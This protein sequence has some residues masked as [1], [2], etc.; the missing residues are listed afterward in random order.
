M[1]GEGKASPG[2]PE[3]EAALRARYAAYSIK[4][5]RTPNK[6]KA[7]P[8]PRDLRVVDVKEERPPKGKEGMEW[9]LAAGE[10]AASPEEAYG[11]AGCY[12]RRWKAGRFHCALKGGR[13]VEKFQKRAID[14][15]TTLI[16]T[17]SI[18]GVM[19]LNMTYAARLAPESPC[20]LLLGE[21]EWKSLY[22]AANKSEQEPKKPYTL[23]DYLGWLGWPKRAPCDGPPGVRTVWIGLMKLY[24]LPDR[25][26][27]LV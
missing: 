19:T 11:Y 4:R 5:P 14:K 13:A 7:L 24:V 27:R 17:R 15:A 2:R 6:V 8:E 9:L 26:E 1:A 21:E 25:R 20:S 22:C 23:K 12:M 16:L 3:R 18:I 10:P